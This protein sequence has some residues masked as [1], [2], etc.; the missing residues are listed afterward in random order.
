MASVLSLG[1][2]LPQVVANIVPAHI[3]YSGPANT[4]TFF[5]PSKRV[6]KVGDAEVEV[7]HF[8]GLRL[9]GE[10]IDLK[11]NSGYIVSKS[12]ILVRGES[13]EEPEI[14]SVNQYSAVAKF[15]ELILYGH[16]A[17]A[18]LGSQWKIMEEWDAIADVI[19]G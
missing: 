17:Q 8:R 13:E 16:E 5:G 7:A 19:H 15:N 9:V 11:Q 6:E 10:K 18:P 1:E 12:E 3:Q 4:A 2:G 14:R